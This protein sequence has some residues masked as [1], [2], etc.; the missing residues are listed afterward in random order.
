ME[1]IVKEF[2]ELSLR[3]L[4]EILRCRTEVFVVEQ[5]IPYQELD[6][7]D[8][9]STHLFVKEGDEIIGYLRIIAPGV[10]NESAVIG[11]VLTMKEHRGH[12]IARRLMEKGI[13][14]AFSNCDSIHIEAQTYLRDFYES[15][16]FEAVSEEF[17]YESRPHISMLLKRG[18]DKKDRLK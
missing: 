12:G 14:T 11:R 2:D 8:F 10:R 13:E 16:G 4:Y 5:A 18:G 1:I 9:S 3:E 6:G 17:I 7:D 15:L